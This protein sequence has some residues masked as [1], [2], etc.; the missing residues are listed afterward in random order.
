MGFCVGLGVGN[1]VPVVGARLDVGT[2]VGRGEGSGKGTA[3]GAAEGSGTGTSVGRCVR[4]RMLTVAKGLNAAEE[5]PNTE[6]QAAT[7]RVQ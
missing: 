7:R 5:S 3:V 4:M 2:W 1:L 6:M